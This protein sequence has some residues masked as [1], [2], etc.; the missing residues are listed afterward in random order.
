M[1]ENE[2]NLVVIA[3]NEHKRDVDDDKKTEEAVST[4]PDAS[5]QLT[6][7]KGDK[8]DVLGGDVDWWLYVKR[9]G[10][11]EKGY[12]PSSC[13]VPLKDDLTDKQLDELNEST[14]LTAG[15][16]NDSVDLKFFPGAPTEENTRKREP[17]PEDSANVFSRL[18]FW[19][20]TRLIYTGYKRAL[21]DA[22]LWALGKANK[23]VTIVPPFIQ[24]WREAENALRGASKSQT[25]EPADIET[26][27][28]KGDDADEEVKFSSKDEKKKKK[29]SL[30]RIMFSLFRFHFLLAIIFKFISDCIM[31]VQPQ[32][33]RLLIDYTEGKNNPEKWTGYVFSVSM[34][35]VA[36]LQ[37]VAQQQYFHV[38]VTLGL[39]VRTAVVGMVYSKAL[40]LNNSARKE[41]TAGEIVNLMSVDAQRLMDLMTFLNALWSSPFQIIVSL[42]FLYNTMGVS[43]L[44][45][46]GVMLLMVPTNILVSRIARKLQVKQMGAKDLRL[47]MMNEILNGIKVLKLYAWETSF[48]KTVSDLRNKELEH[49]KNASYLN[50]SFA[51]TFTCAPFLVSLATFAIYVM[52]GNE[53]T[54]SKAF[55]AISLFNIL[56][57]PMVLFP[58]IIVSV[59]QA[60]VSLQRLTDFLS[61]DEIDSNNVEK[62]MPEHLQTQVIHVENGTFNWDKKDQP[63]LKD[64]NI[65]I[66]SGSL[67]AVVGQVGCGKSTLLS[68]LLGETEKLQGNVYVKGSI[69][70]VPQQAWIQNATLKDNVLFGKP[71]TSKRYAKTIHAC[72]LQ[73]DLD[74]LPGGDMTEIGEKG[75]NLSG[76]QKQRVSLARAVYFDA[77]I[78]LLDDPLSAVDSHVGKHIFDKV[79]GPK[80]KLRKKTR[81]LVTHGISFLPQVDQIIV[82]QDGRISEVGSYEELVKNQGA[83]AE[84]L[85]TYATDQQTKLGDRETDAEEGN[86]SPGFSMEK[87]ETHSEVLFTRKRADSLSLYTIDTAELEGLLTRPDEEVVDR[88]IDEE[89]S[90]SGRVKFAV[91]WDYAKSLTLILSALILLFVISGEAATVASGIWLAI[92]SSSPVSSDSDRDRYL[93]VYGGLGFSQAVFLLFGSI[94]MAIGS[95]IA[96]R[97]LHHKMLVN[98]MHSPMSFFETTPQGRIM[99]RFSKDISGIDDVVPQTLMVFLRTFFNVIGAMFTISYA[100]PIFLVVI[101][102]LLALYV[103]VQRLYVS[104]SRQLKRIESVSRSPIYS[105]FLETI[106]GTTTI[107]AFGQQQ[108]FI[109]DNYFIVDEN[110]VA[111]YPSVSSNRWLA[112]RLE[113]VGNLVIFFAALFSVVNRDSLQSGLVGLSV[114]YA[115]QIT[116]TLNWMVRMSSELEANIVAVERVK[117]YSET[118]TEAEWI[119]PDKRPPDDWP[120]RGSIVIEEFDLKYREGLPLVLK[121]INCGVKPGEKIGIVGRTGA[122]KST[123][124]LALFRILERAGGRIVIDGIDISKIG[125]QD[126]RSRLTII[127]QDPVLF[128]GTLRV[129]L[130][131][132]NNHSD[133]ELWKILELSHLKNFVSGLEQG[134]L[135]PVSEGGE[136]LS[137]GQRQL[138][139]LARALLRKSKVLVLDEATAAVDLE[140]DEVIQQTIRREFAD[141]TV[142]TIAHRLNTVMDYSRIMVLDKGFMVEFDTPKALINKKGIFYSMAADAGLA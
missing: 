119:I 118:P 121:Q 99:N 103:L 11:E 48:M 64:I 107:R 131:P 130:D 128:S 78:Y 101:L 2:N 56:R 14:E 105:N 98:I 135:Y 67:V 141:R 112:I 31:F 109:H 68:A 138:V 5:S 114:T 140:T 116:S 71:F 35:F 102:P 21:T 29:P 22:D 8:F 127:P 1:A 90:K 45:G 58:S 42:Y 20:L 91:F 74:I 76:G 28:L 87:L 6:V 93:G 120:D 113:F 4:A 51:F 32:L 136:N 18:S 44:A 53:L 25:T 16:V 33:L 123:L 86:L 70:Y 66:P 69:A 133:D 97:Q 126:L 89:T 80:G 7:G 125:L 3:V 75:I 77:D 38:M 137:V 23:A 60:Q 46:V 110:Q 49:L 54:A 129:N 106:N 13:V 40:L 108:R 24:K 27:E 82:L 36:L 41:S 104:S 94:S 15:L 132:F 61:L 73:T 52:T 88:M 12:I 84:F 62:T 122:G 65:N 63:I 96:S 57:F 79:I 50:A 117:E 72:A 9:F 59:I 142:F 124:T 30:P 17:C 55:V 100:T 92:W 19:W 10:G 81:V 134:L 95:R 85:S 37:S 111:Y 43:I 26:A 83:F 34:L 139:C 115:L 47:K 39:K